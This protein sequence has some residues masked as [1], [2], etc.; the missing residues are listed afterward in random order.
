LRLPYWYQTAVSFMRFAMGLLKNSHGVYILRKKVPKRLERAV[1]QVQGNGK[2]KQV[3]LQQ[4][5][6]T[7]EKR[8]AERR[9]VPLLLEFDRILAQ[10]EALIAERPLRQSLT[11]GEIK[12][13]AD[14]FYASELASDADDRRDGTGT[15][16][17]FARV[18]DQLLAAGIEFDTPFKPG[19][20]VEFGLT[21]REMIKKKEGVSIVLPAMKTALARGDISR[22]RWEMDELLKLF[23]INLDPQ[24]ISYRKL[25]IS[26][27][28]A[29]VRALEAIQKRNQGEWVE[30]PEPVEPGQ[31]V[32]AAGGGTLNAALAGWERARKPSPAALAEYKRAVA[33]F[34]QLLGDLPIANIRKSQARRFVTALQEVRKL[35][36]KLRGATLPEIL[37]WGREH[38]DAPKL[39]DGTINKLLG[40][41]QAIAVW[42][43]NQGGMV[44]DEVAWSDP[45]AGMRLEDDASDREP[46]TI[47]ELQ[48]LFGSPVFT[49]GDR[50][51]AGQGEAAYWLPLLGLFTGARRGELVGLTVANAQRIEAG[52][53]A[54]V[55]EKDRMLGKSLKTKQSA[56]IIPVHPELTHLG[57]ERYIETIRTKSGPKAWLFPGVAPQSKYGASNW[58]KWFSSHLR[59]TGISDRSKVFHSFRHGFIDALRAAGVNPEVN[60]ALVGHGTGGSVHEGYGA[61]AMLQRYG[62]PQ[63]SRA[64]AS[65]T[66]P[67]LDVSNLTT[68]SSLQ[69]RERKIS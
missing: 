33:L 67:G 8:D 59:E 5:L 21:D 25:G 69:G 46:F 16:E 7:K 15:E 19:A 11:D 28:T 44:P 68:N 4:S 55:L 53:C 61:K 64:V 51:R 32:H 27:L 45:F 12:A 18:H 43:A 31:Q 2:P 54:L 17:L 50:P 30:A 58:S 13:I 6:K 47:A 29:F 48:M 1:A 26:L 39:A 9:A 37:E 65:V 24:S 22:V 14:F 20:T 66:Y 10:A 38:P 3:F 56:R 34:T 63:L 57:F 23:H 49:K 36:A 62:W 35:P 40:G 41:V 52:G 42:G 60:K